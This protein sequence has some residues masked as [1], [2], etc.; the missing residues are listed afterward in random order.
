MKEPLNLFM[1]RDF[2]YFKKS[3]SIITLTIFLL[4]INFSQLR[5]AN[6]SSL[7]LQQQKVT[8]T[9]TDNL[10]NEPLIGVSVLVD[11]TTN[12]TVTDSKGKFSLTVSIQNA[13][14]VFSYIG[15]VTEK[16]ALDGKT[17]LDMKLVPDVKKLEEVVVIGYGTALKKDLTGA[18]A[19]ISSKD[20]NQG[21]ISNPLQQ[22]AGKAPGV[23]VTQV[24]SE[25]GTGL[26][27]R[28]RGITSL[29]G[30]NDPLVVVDG[31]QG[32]MDL[33][34]QIPP[35]EIESFDILKDASATAI[36]GSRGAPGVILITTKRSKAGKFTVEYN[37]SASVDVLANKL[38]MMT[39]D[40]W[41]AQR[42]VWNVPVSTDHGSNTD[43]FN[44]LTKTG[45]TQNHTLSFSGGSENFNYRVSGS[46]ILQD[47]VVLNSN[48][49]KYI[50]LIS[51]TQKAFDNRLTLTVNL[52]DEIE[53]ALNSPNLIGR[54]GYYSNTISNAYESKPTDPVLNPN[55]TYF[56]DPNVFQYINPYAVAKTVTNEAQTNN[57]FG[58]FRADLEII[59]GLTAG[60][61]GSWRKVDR[62]AGYYA[63][64]SSTLD[65]A[66]SANG[67][68]N[69]TTNLQNERLMDINL[70]YK[71]TFGK[72]SIDGIVVYEWQNQTY[73]GDFVQGRNFISDLTTFN[74]LQLGSIASVLPGDM[75]SYKNDRTL[76]SYL[77]RINYGFMD[78]Y[79]VTVSLRR[80]GS[81]VFGAN[82]KWG[83]FPSV[84]LAW[85]LNEES[86]MSN[87]KDVIS[88]LKLRGG[89]GVTGN[90]QGLGPQ[91]SLQLVGASGQLYFNGSQITNY[92]VT[93]NANPD[94]K[95]ETRYE[96]NIGLDF[97][98]FNNRLSGTVDV[99]DAT[100]KN[101]LF[102]YNVPTP[103]YPYTTIVANVGSI[104]NKG[105]EIT[106]NYQLIKNNDMTLVIGG[107]VSFLRNKVINLSGNLNGV[108][109]NSDT[110][111]WGAFN[112]VSAPSFLIKGQPV[113]TFNILRHLGKDASNAET[114]VD[115][116]GDGVIDQ[117]MESKDRFNEGS[118][119]P[120][121][122]Y[123]FTPSFS[124][125][126]FDISMVWRGSGGNKIYN[127]INQHY[128]FFETL[129]K[130]NL[131]ESAA[132]KGLFTS[133]YASDL[134]LEDG[135][136]LRFENLTVGYRFN[137]QKLKYVS[138]IRVSLIANNI[139]LFTKYTGLDPEINVNGA[140][141]F[142]ADG[143]IYP[144]TRSVALG[145]NVV[146]K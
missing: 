52:N 32:N 31:V 98:F 33:L 45:S 30:G 19:K 71:K 114:V 110:V 29:I 144:R 54:A 126:N 119:L 10:T 77:G 36:Y 145:L 41:R 49:N 85:K 66:R 14:L 123:A 55:G 73:Q 44:L 136:F 101:L 133:K 109:L 5:A 107:N 6:P 53:K 120:T 113:G 50:A 111:A 108:Q 96:T 47:G 118:A 64:Y 1:S 18:E 106:L 81:S 8:G 104:S 21:A 61:F 140:N 13:V 79:L 51:A 7:L 72:H 39:A 121:Y 27:V 115:R 143:G 138:S 22:I 97:G 94:L 134:W 87:L 26:S 62:Y 139:A 127:F 43:W 56:F 82:N 129:G 142:G 93:Q 58:T 89:Y 63:P 11:G 84:A 91:N 34:N 70:N 90:Q 35:S 9:V 137:T 16:V 92:A 99:Y 103:P 65:A 105:L 15:Y 69:I 67:L 102:N 17:V 60:W 4:F 75:S 24:G 130:S 124:Y 20:L 132:S 125:K 83:N 80:D 28:I 95:W 3:L 100:T 48:D 146:F 117:G 57:L 37:G 86:F 38:K 116:N 122:T 135:S 42:A 23:S 78:R 46:A 128:S 59:K 2:F 68:A 25:P 12:G 112:N 76:V 88:T 40:E 141:G 74:A 131:L